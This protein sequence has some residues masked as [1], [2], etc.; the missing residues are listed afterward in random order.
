M[1]KHTP[2]DHPDHG[3]LQ[4]AL[5][6]IK[7]LADRMNRGE[8]EVDQAE[9]EAERLR[10][11]EATI[12]GMTEVNFPLCPLREIT[13]CP[14]VLLDSDFNHVTHNGSFKLQLGGMCSRILTCIEFILFSA[15]VSNSQT[16]PARFSG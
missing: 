2:H 3:S 14:K 12:E 8:K 6:E 16:D 5:G 11:L 13:S 7:T 1:I 10:D 4:L 15:G 9:R